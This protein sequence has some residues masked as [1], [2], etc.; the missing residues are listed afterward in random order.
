MGDYLSVCSLHHEANIIAM[1]VASTN[2][3][4]PRS[5]ILSSHRATRAH[6]KECSSVGSKYNKDA[7]LPKHSRPTPAAGIAVLVLST[8]HF[9]RLLVSPPLLHITSRSS[10]SSRHDT[11]RVPHYH[12]RAN[13]PQHCSPALVCPPCVSLPLR[14]ASPNANAQKHRLDAPQYCSTI[15]Q[16]PH[17]SHPRCP[18]PPTR[19]RKPVAPQLLYPTP[20]SSRQ[21]RVSAAHHRTSADHRICQAHPTFRSF[22]RLLAVSSP[23]L[24]HSGV[25]HPPH[26][27]ADIHPAPL[28][29]SPAPQPTIESP[30]SE[31]RF[32]PLLR[33]MVWRGLAW[34]L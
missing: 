8:Y 16:S 10:I 11:S 12:S 17:P 28:A 25:T 34:Y 26:H 32:I 23:T 21:A 1:Y 20:G 5:G 22:Q 33:A 3:R 9:P 24:L 6:W 15:Q 30:I 29:P 7:T 13:I 14:R 18:Q 4:L 27:G 19:P 2:T 31:P